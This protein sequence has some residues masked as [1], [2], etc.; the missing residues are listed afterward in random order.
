[1]EDLGIGF[2]KCPMLCNALLKIS[3]K[4]W[5]GLGSLKLEDLGIGF[6]KCPMLCNA[7]FKN[8]LKWWNGLGSLKLEDLGN[9]LSKICYA[10]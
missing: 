6:Q 2:Q 1:L 5:N 10:L 7:L 3:L 8:S 4:W 9:L